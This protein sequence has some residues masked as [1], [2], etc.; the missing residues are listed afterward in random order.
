M[1]N[2]VLD[3]SMDMAIRLIQRLERGRQGILRGLESVKVRAKFLKE[4]NIDISE[5]NVDDEQD[6]K[7]ATIIQK[8][9]RAFSSRK[10]LY[11][12]REDE[13][14]FLGMK[15]EDVHSDSLA[16]SEKQRNKMKLI[17]KT[18]QNSY[19]EDGPKIKQEVRNTEEYTIKLVMLDERRKWIQKFLEMNEFC[20]VPKDIEMFYQKDNIDV[21]KENIDAKGKKKQ[22]IKK[23]TKKGKKNDLEKFL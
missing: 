22:P 6:I 3:T 23:D 8:F 11:E 19:V 17:Q 2:L 16:I 10:L 7:R 4:K 9:W 12:L 15:K 21:D 18:N 14:K 20:N 13:I 5:I 1:E